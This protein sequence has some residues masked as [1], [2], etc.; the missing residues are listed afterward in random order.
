M[1]FWQTIRLIWHS[2]IVL[3]TIFWG[4]H[5][6]WA[7][8]PVEYRSRNYQ[9]SKS[10]NQKTFTAKNYQRNKEVT[11]KPYQSTPGF[12]RR[13]FQSKGATPTTYL[14]D[15]PPAQHEG[16]VQHKH[17][18]VPSPAVNANQV[19]EKRPLITTK[20]D[21]AGNP[22]EANAKPERENP[23]LK[24]RQGIKEDLE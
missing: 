23:L 4:T 8:E 5:T 22:F 9:S 12:F 24:P 16:Y 3:G 13:L 6:L 17:T 2:G 15:V 10:L 14:Q 1:H 20:G 7:R 18:R 19:Q 21:Y 11:H